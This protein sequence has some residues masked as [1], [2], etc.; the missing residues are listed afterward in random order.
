[1]PSFDKRLHLPVD[2]DA[3]VGKLAR[4]FDEKEKSVPA[5]PSMSIQ[6]SVRVAPVG[7]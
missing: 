3:L 4:P 1:V 7:S 6:P 5:P 2:E